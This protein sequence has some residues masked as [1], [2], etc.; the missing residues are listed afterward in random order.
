M[1][2]IVAFDP[3]ETTG[4]AWLKP[5]SERLV[6]DEIR[7]R[8]HHLYLY[9]TVL[10][11]MKPD[12]VVCESFDHRRLLNANLIARE[13]IGVIA[14]WCQQTGTPLVMQSPSQP[15]K[16]WAMDK[17]KSLNVYNEKMPHANDAMRHLLHYLVFTR[18]QKWR[19]D[20]L[21]PAR[22]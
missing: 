11:A 10:N 12:L 1:G 14:L 7:Q 21:S 18:G 15:K 19:L 4:L 22:P 16:F 6:S 13:Y 20:R 8:N 3:G 9:D 5:G 2:Y 17:L